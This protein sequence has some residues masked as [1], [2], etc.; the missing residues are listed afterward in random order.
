MT[1]WEKRGLPCLRSRDNFCLPAQGQP[2]PD[3]QWHDQMAEHEGTTAP[4]RDAMSGSPARVRGILERV[5]DA[6][7][8]TSTSLRIYVND[9]E[10]FEEIGGGMLQQWE[11][12]IATSLSAAW[13][14]Q[15]HEGKRSY[16]APIDMLRKK[17]NNLRIMRRSP[18]IDALFPE[19]RGKILAA[20]LTRPEKSWYLS[21]LSTFLHTRPSS[22]QREVDALSKAG[23][24]DQSRDGRRVYLKPNA[25]SPSSPI[26]RTCLPRR[27]GWWPVQ[28]A[29]EALGQQIKVAFLYGSMARSEEVSESDVNL[30]VVGK[31]GLSE[32]VPALKRAEAILGRPINPTVY[33]IEEFRRKARA[34]D[35]F[36][37][38]VLG[39]AKQFV[40]G[41][42]RELEQIIG[43]R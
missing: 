31:A 43:E 10:E 14:L 37:T 16:A 36:L 7:A 35:H 41:N 25:L 38:A 34:Q 2:G 5:A 6:I 21:E 23:I 9:H 17:R 18:I 13:P 19:I 26:S 30:M 32:M 24:L 15:S 3:T 42:E 33:S 11:Q 29:L 28:E 27:R 4:W 39:G 20:T 40:K 8:T 12:G 1:C 22:L